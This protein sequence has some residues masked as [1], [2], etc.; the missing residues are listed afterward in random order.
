MEEVVNLVRLCGTVADAPVFSHESRSIR[1]YS[2]PLTA[3]RLSG[4]ADTVNVIVRRSMLDAHPLRPGN[5]VA[6]GGELRSFNNKSGVGAKLVITVYARALE[7]DE[8][9]E[10]ENTAELYG[11]VCKPPILRRTPLG[12]EI[13]DIILAVPRRY[14]RSDYIPV[15]AWGALGREAAQFAV[16]ERL[17]V[18]GRIQ[19]RRYTKMLDGVAMERTAFE[20]SAGELFPL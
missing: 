13:C 17:C 11:T 7:Y 5:R 18:R 19:S 10:D 4:T 12:R 16:G 14:S 9:A 8:S 1:F 3:R 2:F 20:L 15:I 6:L